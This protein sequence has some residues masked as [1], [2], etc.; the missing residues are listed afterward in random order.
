M[1]LFTP[2]W[3]GKNEKKA[4]AFVEKCGDQTMLGTIAVYAEL[5]GVRLA[6]VEKLKDQGALSEIV[7]NE[8]ENI[9]IR[10]AAIT[11]IM[12]KDNFAKL[13]FTL[14]DEDLQLKAAASTNN[15]I[16]LKELAIKAESLNIQKA[17]VEQIEN[18]QILADVVMNS[19][20]ETIRN[21]AL[22]WIKDPGTHFNL[23]MLKG[24]PEE[25]KKAVEELPV[26]D[27]RL[28][29]IASGKNI[30]ATSKDI[31]IETALQRITSREKLLE[32]V[33]KG[34]NASQVLNRLDELG[35]LDESTLVV[36]ANRGDKSCVNRLLEIDPEKYIE[37]YESSM[38]D[39]MRLKAIDDGL[40]SEEKLEEMAIQ[41]PLD[42]DIRDSAAWLA[43]VRIQSPE[44]L[45]RILLTRKTAS[46]D[47]LNLWYKR[48]LEK[49]EHREDVM[50]RFVLS[51]NG[52]Q[53]IRKVA[54]EHITTPEYL[55]EIA[56]ENNNFAEEAA[57][58][59]PKKGEYRQKLRKSKNRNVAALG[60][61]T[62]VKTR[63]KDANDEELA[64][65]LV[66]AM[67]NSD[68]NDMEQYRAA[69]K[70]IQSQKAILR[71]FDAYLD[72]SIW[73][74]DKW[75]WLH[76]ILLTQITDGAGL[77][78][79]CLEYPSLIVKDD[80]DRLK[81]LI[82]GTDEEKKF[83]ENSKKYLINFKYGIDWWWRPAEPSR[84]Y[85]NLPNN[86]AAAWKIGG[87]EFVLKVL[88]MLEKSTE[89]GTTKQLGG[90]LWNI[91]KFVPESH[92]VLKGQKDR[93]LKKHYDYY[94]EH[95]MG[96]SKSYM[97][98]YILKLEE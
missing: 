28:I 39:Q 84:R 15:Q 46:N 80:I 18:Q 53:D 38:T 26:N 54:L 83:M 86:A 64:D 19:E 8:R 74:R 30:P 77:A 67:G 61:E 33:A 49:L 48:L 29:D 73:I 3:K 32:V 66:W 95:C 47:I 25:R 55:L 31:I 22:S 87:Q 27:N 90:I 82:K 91:Y 9:Q 5:E 24:T 59:L 14:P 7:K 45:E 51:N 43:M 92:E 36:F 78:S 98:D 69:A 41:K 70:R 97:T 34:Q 23:I 76:T 85:F 63:Q 17:A 2:A 12:N 93:K 75:A 72:R 50:T 65:F 35:L 1:G 37:R 16:K 81:E 96:N 71:V 56:M 20:N 79:L 44:R 11:N 57:R 58:R 21:L 40:F 94:D 68:C 42:T 10:R 60:M 4:L 89:I 52:P 6:A 62:W 13:A 88:D